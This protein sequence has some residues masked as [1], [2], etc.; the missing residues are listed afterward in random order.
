MR[1]WK[2]PGADLPATP[3]I[4][5]PAG[6]AWRYDMDTIAR[7]AGNRPH[8]SVES[9]LI[10]AKWAHPHWHSYALMLIH[11]RNVPGLGQ[12]KLYVTGATHEVFLAALNPEKVRDLKRNPDYM[13][14]LNF[15]AQF[16]AQDDAAATARINDTVREVVNG[17]LSPDT[18]HMQSW[19]RR[20]G[21]AMIKGD[22]AT[23]G[24]TKIIISQ[25]GK[26]NAQIVFPPQAPKDPLS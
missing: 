9:W 25:P 17:E 15:A 2:K 8:A 7:K 21:S 24:E 4:Q 14:P 11:L 19:I 12:P 10:E 13:M 16:I 18:D 1:F 3:D 23:A 22:P 26:E 5:G 6:R 20:Y